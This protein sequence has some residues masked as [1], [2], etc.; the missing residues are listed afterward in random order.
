MLNGD[1]QTYE[2]LLKAIERKYPNKNKSW[3]LEKNIA[4][5][6]KDRS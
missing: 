2:R 6:E 5:L 4:D 1:R 3:W